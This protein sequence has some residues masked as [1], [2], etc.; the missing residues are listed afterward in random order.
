[1][2]E[3][4]LF[5]IRELLHH[6]QLSTNTNVCNG[7]THYT[8]FVTSK[9]CVVCRHSS[10]MKQSCAFC[11]QVAKG[12]VLPCRVENMGSSCREDEILA[13]VLFFTIN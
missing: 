7:L 2:N 5:C 13:A 12:L 4:A 11:S 1:M 6:T 10:C 8:R 9:S 3:V